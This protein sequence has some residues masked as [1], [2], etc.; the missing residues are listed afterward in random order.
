MLGNKQTSPWLCACCFF[1]LKHFWYERVTQK[2]S[3][4]EGDSTAAVSSGVS[5]A[6][7]NHPVLL[8]LS[9]HEHRKHQY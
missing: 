2:P 7:Q 4:A 1:F 3:K 5:T 6:E 9:K 8:L